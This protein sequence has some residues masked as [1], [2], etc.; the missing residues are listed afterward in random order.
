MQNAEPDPD[1]VHLE[2]YFRKQCDVADEK[3]TAE[4][5]DTS[6]KASAGQGRTDAGDQNKEDMSV[7]LDQ[8]KPIGKTQLNA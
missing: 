2:K 4:D 6:L 7:F 8:I 3:T 5:I 1:A